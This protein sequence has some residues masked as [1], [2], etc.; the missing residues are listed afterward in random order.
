MEWR[1][2]ATRVFLWISVLAWGP[3]LG[4][5]IFDLLVLAGA[6]SANPPDSLRL[7]P[8]S[9]DYPVDTGE[10]FI[11]SSAA[12][13][14]ASVGALSAGWRTPLS[15]RGLL[16]VSAIA[17][18]STLVLTVVCFWP[19]NSALWAYA[20]NSPG[21]SHSAEEIAMIAHRWVMLDWV[22]V[23]AA[24]VGFIASIRALSISYPQERT[25]AD[26]VYIKILLAA[27]LIGVAVF[28][29]YFVSNI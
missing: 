22:R 16:A 19:M 9:A 1:K 14:L 27:G 15:Y 4:A 29:A 17:I 5:K 11:P 6:W 26:P 23:G 3:L 2:R 12:L 13:L 20:I 8:Y 28:V 18:F 10:F 24:A 25:N 21:N 7:L